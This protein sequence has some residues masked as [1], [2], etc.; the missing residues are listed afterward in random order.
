MEYNTYYRARDTLLGIMNKD[1]LGPVTDEEIICDERPLDYYMLGKLYPQKDTSDVKSSFLFESDLQS[2]SEDC[3]DVEVEDQ[4]YISLCNG[5]NPS[6]FGLSFSL[7]PDVKSFIIEV[8]AAAYILIERDKA[9]EI[10]KFADEDYKKSASFWQRRVVADDV[11]IPVKI[12][13]LEV[14]KANT[15]PICDGL[16]LSILLHKVY[17]DGSMTITTT[18][19]NGYLSNDNYKE[20][21]L[22]AFFQ[23]QLRIIADIVPSFRDVRRNVDLDADPEIKEMNMLYHRVHDFA[24]G[25]GCASDWV[26]DEN[27]NALVLKTEF[28]PSFEMHQMMPSTE[29]E[30]FVLSMKYLSEASVKDISIGLK[31]LVDMYNDWILKQR[32]AAS[33][34]PIEFHLSAE[35]NFKK[36]EEARD[37]LY[38]S[39]NELNNPAI[40]QAFQLSN[41]AMFMQRKKILLNNG[42]FES[43]DKI[44]WYPFQLA[45]FVQEIYSFARPDSKERKTV[46]LLWFPTGGGKTEAYL[47]IAAFAIFLRRI[48]KGESANGVTVLMRYTLRL[49]SFQQFERAASLIC[50]CEIIRKEQNIPG[51]EIGIGL[52]AGMDLTPNYIKDAKKILEGNAPSYLKNSNPA[53]ITKC[54]W[55]GTNIPAEEP[56]YHCDTDRCRIE[57]SCPNSDCEFC[58]GLPIYL[59]DE[60]IYRYLP[61]YIVATV[62]KFAQL[63]LNENTASLFGIN[64]K[65]L[66]PELII[67][68]ELHL[69]SGP[70]GTITGLYEAAIKKLC[71]HDG[72][73]PKV[74]AS[75]ATIRNAGEQIK[76]LYA[77]DY[78]Q[79]PPQG[80][81]INNSFFAVQ[82]SKEK[83]P[84]RLYLGCMAIGTSPTTMLIRVMASLLFATRYLIQ[85]G[86]N[87]DVI[88][89]FW[90]ITGYFNTLREL[91]GAIVRVVDD[92]QDRF[93]FLKHGKFKT[94]YPLTNERER[95][96]KYKELTSREKGEDIGSIIQNELK[97]KYTA[98]GSTF[99][100]DY[101]LASSMI[102]VGVDVARL[103]IMVVVNQPKSTSEYIQATSRVGRETPGLVTT[104]YNQVRSR[105]RSH[106]EQFRQYHETFY[107]YVEATSVT[108]FSDRAR[109]RALQALFVVLCRYQ[110]NDLRRNDDAINF[111]KDM[112]GVKEIKE[113]IL[114]Y[115]RIVDP[116]EA[117]RVINELD[118]IQDEWA[119]RAYRATSLKYSNYGRTSQVLFDP[120]YMEESR[121]RILNSMRSVET[122]VNAIEKE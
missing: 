119:S 104:T 13:E 82:S 69:I 39:I 34:L 78:T 48:T 10:L 95:Y 23:P 4:D 107:K 70:L 58:G 16:F 101:L 41:K 30:G 103:G 67:Q 91:G 75:T 21:C 5:R 94:L 111:Q 35:I 93:A 31:N 64:R 11:R 59:I 87:D 26:V 15:T 121:F 40:F 85:L 3:G 46:D 24:S 116:E 47:G 118:S 88:D 68:D 60:E 32:V 120:D 61:T 50:A 1:F 43:D 9:K 7:L 28:S 66:P 83:K 96:D 44:T 51:G 29:F 77:S 38:K 36:C 79:F 84:A 89:S 106:Y 18:L 52:W 110:I 86:Y 54:P 113:Y 122:M 108:P 8:D 22:K 57:I 109:D 49:L 12:D 2:P 56:F 6:S 105:D 115:V 65:K 99:P 114:N 25:H 98:D 73:H 37:R 80:I 100:Y 62:D 74:V 45:F 55:C 90:T 17:D 112:P 92:I 14:G 42:K 81:D 63:A 76:A 53:Q 102:S 20:E 27:G 117:D 71:E 97:I 72:G 19:V 33:N